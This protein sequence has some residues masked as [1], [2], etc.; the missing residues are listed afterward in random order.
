ME[1]LGNRATSR[2]EGIKTFG[3]AFEDLVSFFFL[4]YTREQSGITQ[5]TM[6]L[7]FFS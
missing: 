6:F 4:F 1:G 2:R 5:K 3:F 7:H